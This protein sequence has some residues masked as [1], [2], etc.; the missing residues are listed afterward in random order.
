M[1]KG[2]AVLKFNG[3]NYLVSCEAR[4]KK[5]ALEFREIG[6]TEALEGRDVTVSLPSSQG[7]LVLLSFPF[8]DRKKIELVLK[9][10]LERV[11]PHPVDDMGVDFLEMGQGQ[12][13]CLA[14]QRSVVE[15]V[16][17]NLR[18]VCVTTNVLSAL[19]AFSFFEA[20]KENDYALLY[21]EGSL[22]SVFRFQEG[23]LRLL[24]QSLFEP[25]SLCE[26]IREY[27][28]EERVGTL[29]L[30]GAADSK[31][32]EEIL[33][34]EM[35]VHIKTPSISNYV[36]AESYPHWIWSA[37]GAALLS[38]DPKAHIN[39]LKGERKSHIRMAHVFSSAALVLF[40]VSL[41]FFILAYTDLALKRNVLKEL[42]QEELRIYKSLFQ[43]SPPVTEVERIIREKVRELSAE[44]V[45]S[46]QVSPLRVLSELSRSILPSIDVRLTEFNFDGKGFVISGATTSL[47]NLEKIKE[48]LASSDSVLKD[49]VVENVDLS[50]N[51]VKFKIRGSL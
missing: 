7:F 44:R 23:T 3:S 43:G 32:Y 2:F 15:G 34:R 1:R 47:S 10:E 19:Y 48:A 30:I 45:G 38:L 18:P 50:G 9:N 41:F 49:I 14:V 20:P 40:T 17:Q 39:L 37:A 16:G 8:R 31:R 46:G 22:L 21:I 27:L 4:K 33:L 28:G 6:S 12:V 35:G 11:L 24:R 25:Q 36:E 5:I 13:L 42:T 51:Q 26:T 29:Y